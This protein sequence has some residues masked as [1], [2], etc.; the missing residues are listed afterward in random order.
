M[1]KTCQVMSTNAFNKTICSDAC[2]RMSVTDSNLHLHHIVLP[3][4]ERVNNNGY[5]IVTKQK[6]QKLNNRKRKNLPCYS[7]II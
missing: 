7:T 6:R 3:I 4:C 1:I 2:I 5:K